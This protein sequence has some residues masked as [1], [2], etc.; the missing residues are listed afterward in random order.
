MIEIPNF[1]DRLCEAIRKKKSILCCGL[2]PQLCYMPPHLIRTAVEELGRTY[3]AVGRV[4]VNFNRQI[5][6]AVADIVVCVKPNFAFY[7]AYGV[8]GMI[9]LEDTIAYAKGKGL[10]V[11]GDGK[12]NDGGDTVDAY[13]D[14]HLGE[15][16]FFGDGDDPAV[17]KSVVSPFRVDALTVNG[18][19]GEA[20]VGPFV[21]KVKEHGSGIFVVAKTSFKPDSVIEQLVVAGVPAWQAMAF[22][23]QKW[24]EGTEGSCGLR[25]VGVV[26]GAT[27]PQDAPKMRELLP[28]SIFLVPGFGGQGATADDAVIGVREDGLGAVV[29]NSRNLIYAWR[30]PKGEYQCESEKFAE[31][32]RLQALH[33]CGMLRESCQ[34][35]S[36]WPF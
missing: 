9:A 36:K 18:Y 32:A 20:C 31:A 11:I 7:E 8:D 25:N 35:A 27:Y 26:L 16:P 5:I 15:V 24:G 10:L 30:N 3:S 17:L 4:F 2:D 19:I 23:V 22:Y 34:K 29:N 6:D 33:D 14:G 28:D 12:R 1:A 13:A 21:K